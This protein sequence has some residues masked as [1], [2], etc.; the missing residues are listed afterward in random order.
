M[1]LSGKRIAVTGAGGFIGATVCRL[2]TERGAEVVGLD[3]DP[4][5]EARVRE[6]G[7]DFVACDVTDADAVGR[8]LDGWPLVVH[9]AAI[10][11]EWGDMDE[12]E[13]VNV[14]GTHN[15]M[16]AASR[17]ERVVHL[18]SVAIWGAELERDVHEDEPPRPCGNPYVDTKGASELVARRRG[19]TI[20]R[21]GDVYGPGSVPW[22]IRIVKGLR[23]GVLRIPG[24]GDGLI[25]PVYVDDL[26][27][28]VLLALTHPDGAGG[29]FTAW[30]GER[31]PV[32][33]FFGSYARMLGK[34]KAPSIPVPVARVVAGAEELLG[35]VTGRHPTATTFGLRYVS[36]RYAYDSPRAREVLGWEPQV[37][38][39]EGMRRTE[40]WL[41]K[42]GH[43][44][45]LPPAPRSP[46]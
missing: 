46:G 11:T 24:R 1:D 27:E 18:S 23:S 20:V 7:A 45:P 6:A 36:R 32:H 43:L 15:V 22:A 31:V 12:F 41:R 34:P 4:G 42:T 25:T 33:A 16:V 35:R 30:S 17:A 40:A 8:A 10:V 3:A 29:V 37:S 5:R 39:S 2:A 19:A 26:A 13:R 21:P 38:L 44:P 9:T 14:G 28:C